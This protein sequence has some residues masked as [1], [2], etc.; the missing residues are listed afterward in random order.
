MQLALTKQADYAIRALLDLAH[1]HP[2]RRTTRQITRAMDLPRNMMTQVLATLVRHDILDS[3][4]GPTG[5]YTL[6][7]PPQDITLLQVIETIEGPL[8]QNE[9]AL[10]GGTCEW[11]TLC[12]LHQTWSQAKT[13][14][15]DQL[16]A[17]AFA[18]LVRS[19]HTARRRHRVRCV[20]GGRLESVCC[21]SS[22]LMEFSTRHVSTP[23]P[24]SAVSLPLLPLSTSLPP[25]PNSVSSPVRP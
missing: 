7:R 4:A 17:T 22:Q 2:Q 9:C 10:G 15:T 6:A 14:F 23:G 19:S 8:T 1:R 13:G 24:P 3:R 16:T 25:P 12:P 20:G 5:G 21:Q 11:E 18:D